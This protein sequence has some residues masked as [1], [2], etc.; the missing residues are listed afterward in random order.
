MDS[1]RLPIPE[2]PG[3]ITL[4]EVALRT[5]AAHD[6]S[7]PTNSPSPG[8][9]V[10]LKRQHFLMEETVPLLF[11]LFS[12][13][14]VLKGTLSWDDALLKD[15]NA[16]VPTRPIQAL[17]ET[18]THNGIQVWKLRTFKPLSDNKT[19]ITERIEGWAPYL[20]KALV[21]SEASKGH[22]AH[23]DMYHSLC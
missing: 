4:G 8:P 10:V 15:D 14:I 18:R 21:Q 11:G 6:P 17:Y 12:S 5:V 19:E 1:I 2:Y 20:L 9:E 3:G 23:M 7:S 16:P 22:R 13:R